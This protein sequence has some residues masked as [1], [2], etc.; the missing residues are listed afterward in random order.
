MRLYVMQDSIYNTT[1]TLIHTIDGVLV[2]NFLVSSPMIPFLPLSHLQKKHS[3][4]ILLG[5]LWNPQ[6]LFLNSPNGWPTPFLRPVILPTSC[7]QQ[8]EI[9]MFF[10]QTGGKKV[11]L[12]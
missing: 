1:R 8:S 7:V 2:M 12:V 6:I 11:S 9:K 3:N 4:F 5:C 10:F